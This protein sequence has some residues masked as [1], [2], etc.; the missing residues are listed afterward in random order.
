MLPEVPGGH[1]IPGERVLFD[2]CL[3][4]KRHDTI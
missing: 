4:S 3:H 1:E 2:H